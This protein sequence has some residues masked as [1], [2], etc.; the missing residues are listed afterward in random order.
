MR[1]TRDDVVDR[2]CLDGIETTK[3][4]EGVDD[5]GRLRGEERWLSG[6]ARREGGGHREGKAVRTRSRLRP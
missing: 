6:R 5:D 1:E 3:N 4:A 2:A